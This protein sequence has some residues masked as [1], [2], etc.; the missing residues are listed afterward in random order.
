MGAV[1]S[2]R[3]VRVIPKDDPMT[4]PDWPQL[5]RAIRR[6]IADLLDG[7]KRENSPEKNGAVPDSE[8]FSSRLNRIEAAQK[9]GPRTWD[10]CNRLLMK[11]NLSASAVAEP[12]LQG[13]WLQAV[14]PQIRDALLSIGLTKEEVDP[15]IDEIGVC[16]RPR[17]VLP[18]VKA[19]LDGFWGQKLSRMLAVATQTNT[20]P[21]PKAQPNQP[22]GPDDKQR[23]KGR[24]SGTGRNR[25]GKTI[26][27]GKRGSQKKLTRLITNHD[28]A[29]AKRILGDPSKYPYMTAREVAAALGISTKAVYE[30]PRIEK[31][32]TGNRS[33]R[34]TTASV[35][36]I[37]NS[38]PQ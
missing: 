30:H 8:L 3:P 4:T 13:M 12:F 28:R 2:D 38:L 17:L 34:W 27:R 23:K 15:I 31:F 18:G 11:H 33:R 1:L 32:A 36:A 10:V 29:D 22:T 5:E 35:L 21:S 19:V 25:L 26:K 20:T 14:E 37:I 24:R 6:E 7:F 16:T 9:L